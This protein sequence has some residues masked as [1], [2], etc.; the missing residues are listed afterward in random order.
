MYTYI[1]ISPPFCISL[2][3]SLSHP[4]RW[5]QSTNEL[6]EFVEL[7]LSS[8][9]RSIQ[10]SFLQ[11]IS[12]IFWDSYNCICWSFW[13]CPVNPSGSI[14]FSSFFFSSWSSDSTISNDLSSSLLILPSIWVC[15]WT[16][17]V[18][19]S[20]QLLYCHLQN[21]F[22]L[23]HFYTISLCWYSYFVHILFAWFSL[24][25]CPGF[26]LAFLHV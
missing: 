25:L 7:C 9:F 19:F 16:P 22:F 13:W 23:A 11:I 12:L 1:P 20:I 14:H 18:N 21:F 24:V 8:N 2:P 17:P 15:C 4:S 6:L 5:S 10:P 26:P 3:P